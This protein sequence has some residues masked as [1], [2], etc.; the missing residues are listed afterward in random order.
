MHGVSGVSVSS[1]W[2][3]TIGHNENKEVHKNMGLILI[4]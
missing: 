1:F 2:G 3:D 4:G